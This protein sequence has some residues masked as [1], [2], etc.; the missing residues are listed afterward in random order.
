MPEFMSGGVPG[1]FLCSECPDAVK[2]GTETSRPV[3]ITPLD[4]CQMDLKSVL[5]AQMFFGL[6]SHSA[7][8]THSPREA[9]MKLTFSPAT[10]D[11]PDETKR[12]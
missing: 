4:R 9:Y 2:T 5:V 8:N 11:L 3:S 1:T 6:S 10:R 12:E 7:S